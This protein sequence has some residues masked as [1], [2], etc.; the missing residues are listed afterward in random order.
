MI[1]YCVEENKTTTKK[2]KKTHLVVSGSRSSHH[3]PPPLRWSQNG[4]KQIR[5]FRKIIREMDLEIYNWALYK[6]HSGLAPLCVHIDLRRRLPR[7]YRVDQTACHYRAIECLSNYNRQ[8]K[9]NL[10]TMFIL[11]KISFFIFTAHAIFSY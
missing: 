4:A 9:T 1:M 7:L 11:R 6:A 5:F 10:M 2:G 3:H 8:R